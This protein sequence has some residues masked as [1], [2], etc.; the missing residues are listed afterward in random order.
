MAEIC[1]FVPDLLA[2]DM[3][4]AGYYRFTF[5]LGQEWA[6]YWKKYVAMLSDQPLSQQ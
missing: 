2:P 5:F 6:L 3:I 4:V 1:Q